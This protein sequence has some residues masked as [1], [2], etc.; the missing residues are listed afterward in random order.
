MKYEVAPREFLDRMRRMLA[1]RGVG[2]GRVDADEIRAILAEVP[3][4]ELV[5]GTRYR[6]RTVGG[7]PSSK[8]VHGIGTDR[9]TG[10][11]VHVALDVLDVPEPEWIEIEGRYLGRGPEGTP[12]AR[13][14]LLHLDGLE[15]AALADMDVLSI[16]ELPPR[17]E[18]REA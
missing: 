3:P 11:K 1:A 6:V 12:F 13:M 15:L 9:E 2:T 7:A 5:R 17:A 16:E 4:I 8:H 14:L 10:R 18:A